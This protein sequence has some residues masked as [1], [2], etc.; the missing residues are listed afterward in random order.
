MNAESS[1]HKLFHTDKEP[2]KSLH[3][4]LHNQNKFYLNS[5]NMIDRKA[6][7]MIKVNATI[8]S[9]IIIFFKHIKNL[10]YGRFI[11]VMMVIFSFASLIFAINA[12]R[13]HLFS[14][15]K[16]YRKS[17]LSKHHKLEENLFIVG[18][19]DNIPIE[20]YEKAYAKLLVKPDLHFGNQVRAMYG[21]EKQIKNSFAQIELAYLCFMI[22]FLIIVIGFVYSNVEH[23][24]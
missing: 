8:I 1:K 15:L 10:E 23:W 13:P 7:I 4:F 14:L 5:F 22:G 12:S 9:A 20:E 11:G 18:L 2:R 3:T 21:L 16:N 6:A 19:N 17:I 24:L